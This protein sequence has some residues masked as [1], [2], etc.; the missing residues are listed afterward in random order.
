V[1]HFTI[2]QEQEE[3]HVVRTDHRRQWQRRQ[4]TKAAPDL[5]IKA[6]M[7]NEVFLDCNSKGRYLSDWPDQ[8]TQKMLRRR[9]TH[10]ENHSS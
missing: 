8:H 6:Y 2:T 4:D 9:H 7:L 10:S 3:V 5:T 1:C